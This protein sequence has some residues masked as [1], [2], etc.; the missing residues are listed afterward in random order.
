VTPVEG[1]ILAGHWTQPGTGSVRVIVS[2]MH[3]AELVLR[4]TGSQDGSGFEH[5]DYPPI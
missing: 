3:A 4:S 1:L 5:S 2:G